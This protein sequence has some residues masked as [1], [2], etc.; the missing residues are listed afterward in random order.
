MLL[1]AE[2]VDLTRYRW[3]TWAAST[4]RHSHWLDSLLVSSFY[5]GW[6]SRYLVILQPGSQ[7]AQIW[8]SLWFIIWVGDQ[9]GWLSFWDLKWAWACDG[10]RRVPPLENGKVVREVA[11]IFPV[12]AVILLTVILC[13]SLGLERQGT[14]SDF[15]CRVPKWDTLKVLMHNARASIVLMAWCHFQSPE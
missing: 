5:G 8:L 9:M 14:S 4:F 2:G 12:L 10:S 6:L 7:A 11:R 15:I 13:V 1:I 3:T